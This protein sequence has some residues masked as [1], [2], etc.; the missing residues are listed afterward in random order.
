M[1]E[2]SVFPTSFAQRRLWFIQTM[3]PQNTAYNLVYT[4]ELQFNPDIVALQRALNAVVARHESLRTSFTF[5]DGQPWQVIAPH[6]ELPVEVHDLRHHPEDRKEQEFTRL[7][8]A[9]VA[10]PFD[11][12]RPPLVR[13][14]LALL[15]ES[16]SRLAFVIHHIIA[17]AHS[18]RV[19]TENIGDAYR[20]AVGGRIVVL[21]ELPIQYADYSAWQHQ[22]LNG[23]SFKKS[24][25]YWRRRLQGVPELDL[26]HDKPRPPSGTFHGAVHPF[27]ISAHTVRRLRSSSGREGAT[28]F[29]ILLAG[30][31]AL[32][33]RFSGQ[34][35]FAIGVP[36]SGRP[37]PELQQIV[38]LFVNSL[39]FR[40]DLSGELTFQE[41]L[42]R[43]SLSL[44]EDLTHQEFP[45][46]LIVDALGSQRRV[47]RNPLFQVMFQLQSLEHAGGSIGT[48]AANEP[49]R[50]PTSGPATSQFDLSFIQHE[51]IDGG[52]EGAAVYA[53]E[54]FEPATIEQL[55][56][57]YLALLDSASLDPSTKLHELKILDE[58]RRHKI[59]EIGEGERR[60]W[61][62]DEC[63]HNW[64]AR[65]AKSNADLVAVIDGASETT[66]ADL[67]R[68]SDVVAGNLRRMGLGAGRVAA[69]CLPR[70]RQL[71]VAILGVLKAGGA[72]VC[73][74]KNAPTERLRFILENS[75]AAVV[76]IDRE[77]RDI[78]EG[79]RVLL[80]EHL[81]QPASIVTQKGVG[82][83][84]ASA[85]DAA[86]VIYTSGSTGKPK[87]VAISHRAIVN[88]M[89]WMLEQFPMGADDRVLQRTP[90]TFDAAIWEVFAPLLSGA[91]M[92]LQ[93]EEKLFDP[94]RLLD[95]IQ[96]RRITTLQV[97][98]T[99]L[100][101]LLSQPE[102]EKCS[103]LKRVFCGGEVLTAELRDACCQ[104]S[105]ATLCNLYGP[106]ET[107]IDATFHI[108]NA[109][110]KRRFVPIGRPVAN[111]T[112]RVLDQRQGLLPLGVPGELYIGGAAVG[113]GYLNQPA[114]TAERFI[115]DPFVRGARL[116]R[117]GDRV[118][119][120]PDGELQY[121]GRLD[122][123]VKLRGFRI[124]PGEIESTLLH[125]PAVH[126][127]VTVVQHHGIDDQR[128]V[129]FIVPRESNG[130]DLSLE[131]ID[132]LRE[133]LPHYLVPSSIEITSSLP[134]T[135]HGKVNRRMLAETRVRDA[136][137][138]EVMAPPRHSVERA[139]CRSF[140]EL[141]GIG[142]VGI[143]DDFFHLGGHS[144]LALSLQQKLVNTL[145]QEVAVT[146][147]FEFPTPRRLAR[148]LI[149]RQGER[150]SEPLAVSVAVNRM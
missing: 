89:H 88:H 78:V 11:L 94:A 39:V 87:G 59:L 80:A 47:D 60:D 126:E 57:A 83:E 29:G 70:S 93:P 129:A 72:F 116:Y 131:L 48:E 43:T 150:I 120:L 44:A 141:L 52:I 67:D 4:V 68:R 19:L 106:T 119:L 73:I 111:V 61:P 95:V 54:L 139:I 34:T 76:V 134:R 6:G 143:D 138:R 148:E 84:V 65:C 149:A 45:F 79:S 37:K 115:E 86:Y 132:W 62:H 75:N 50:H 23:P 147:I 24:A 17:D 15:T 9:S 22:R 16:H 125:H 140:E 35:S 118:R 137:P 20:A 40:V 46:E 2:P 102:F 110:D 27:K 42:K 112:V 64:F 82:E 36:V 114:L 145:K 92:V 122:N 38:G 1:A 12:T 56:Q 113:I 85:D 127:A 77:P 18:M 130:S 33:G 14:R 108:C 32:L 8:S 58:Q 3:S 123:Q 103:T 105:S 63:L 7:L 21:P 99:L 53:T 121:L 55:V 117:T 128:L 5:Q 135:D 100:G 124:E 30:F 98:P 133:R 31:S 41:L 10:E 69:I 81:E 142:T 13:V 66:F 136:I 25:D 26:M 74:D 104:K 144:I 49:K 107:T 97:V 28:L 91:T 96:R 90:L 109:N 71:I 51:S 101:A 146:D